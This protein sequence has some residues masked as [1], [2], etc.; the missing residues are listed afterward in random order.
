MRSRGRFHRLQSCF[1]QKIPK[2]GSHASAAEWWVARWTHRPAAPVRCAGITGHLGRWDYPRRDG[3]TGK[4]AEREDHHSDNQLRRMAEC[5]RPVGIVGCGRSFDHAW[6]HGTRRRVDEGMIDRTR[7]PEPGG[8][9]GKQEDPICPGLTSLSSALLVL[10]DPRDDFVPCCH[11]GARVR[12]KRCRRLMPKHMVAWAASLRMRDPSAKAQRGKAGRE[13]KESYGSAH[14][15]PPDCENK[16]S[17]SR[18]W[19]LI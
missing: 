9:A 2:T 1:A 5:R 10:S 16:I 7:T 11:I 3:C 13:Q 18:P 6:H 12:D 8:A 19:T 15:V 14:V 4:H 17:T